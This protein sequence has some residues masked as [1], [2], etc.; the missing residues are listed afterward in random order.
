[1]V[2]CTAAQT[3]I[4]TDFIFDYSIAFSKRK[5]G[6]FSFFFSFL[7]RGTAGTVAESG[8][9][10]RACAGNS[11]QTCGERRIDIDRRLFAYR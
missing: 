6:I 11:V 10:A 7:K 4:E 1:M 2:G 9:E 5:E 3:A 8:G